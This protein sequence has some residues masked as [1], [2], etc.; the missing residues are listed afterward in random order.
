MLKM[1]RRTLCPQQESC[2]NTR[3]ARARCWVDDGLEQGM[4]VSIYYDPMIAK[5]ITFGADRTE[6]IARMKRLFGIP[7]RWGYKHAGF[8]RFCDEPWSFCRWRIQYSFCEVFFSK[9]I[10]KRGCGTRSAGAAAVAN[11]L[12][13][14]NSNKLNL[15][16]KSTLWKSNGS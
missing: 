14:A 9:R 16:E 6:A 10:A 1:L 5:L 2:M 4:E 13:K 7:H 3:A 8:C 11:Y 15:H 12:F